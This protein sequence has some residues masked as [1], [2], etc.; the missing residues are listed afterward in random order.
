MLVRAHDVHVR[1]SARRKAAGL[2]CGVLGF[3][4]PSIIHSTA[5]RANIA[6]HLVVLT[7]RLLIDLALRPQAWAP[8]LP[9]QQP[10]NMM[11]LSHLE[12]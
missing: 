12:I 9:D 7:D 1:R 4:L 3:A 10:T 11:T 6:S 5:P 8:R 2:L